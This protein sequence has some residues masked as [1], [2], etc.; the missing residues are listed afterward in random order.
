MSYST[1]YR[2]HYRPGV[3][4]AVRY[5]RDHA[6]PVIDVPLAKLPKLSRR[7][8]RLALRL[9]PRFLDRADLTF[10]IIVAGRGRLQLT[11]DGR[12]RISKAIHQGISPVPTVHVPFWFATELVFPGVYELE[13]VVLFLRGELA[14]AGQRLIH[15]A[16]HDVPP[17][18][19]VP[20]SG[21][22]G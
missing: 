9:N 17:D 13:W 5:L 16:P 1:Q 10:P 22:G 7:M 15:H 3:F 20:P 14:R 4:L 8:I 21:N 2:W 12:H 18:P 6:V 19:P 11:L